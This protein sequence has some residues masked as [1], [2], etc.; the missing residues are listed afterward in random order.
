VFARN[1][2]PGASR[3]E[4]RGR[5]MARRVLGVAIL[6]FLGIA[7]WMIPWHHIGTS[8]SNF[9]AQENDDRPG[10]IPLDGRAW[11]VKL[12]PELFTVLGNRYGG[13][14]KTTF[15]VPKADSDSDYGSLGN[16]QFGAVLLSRCIA[17][18]EL[19]DR[20]PAGTV[21]WCDSKVTSAPQ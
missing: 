17:T 20:S 18:R 15:A 1:Q 10:W 21:A 16:G 4:T 8:L 6:I 13:D 12:F 19:E 9:V 2:P 14:G 11:S 5:P 3:S 7:G